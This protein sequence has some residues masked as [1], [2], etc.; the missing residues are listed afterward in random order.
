MPGPTKIARPLIDRSG[1]RL[2]SGSLGWGLGL[3]GILLLSICI[4]F[5]GTAVDQATPK[6][7]GFSDIPGPSDTQ[8]RRRDRVGM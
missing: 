8:G 1:A 2:L 7:Q 6:I 4:N 3:T 5:S